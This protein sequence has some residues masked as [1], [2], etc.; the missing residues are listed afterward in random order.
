MPSF[1]N[2][3][4]ALT[5]RQKDGAPKPASPPLSPSV[6]TLAGLPTEI[7]H[8]IAHR[9]PISSAAVLPLVNKHFLHIY[10]MQAWESLK[11]DITQRRVFLYLLE[12][13]LPDYYADLQLTKKIPASSPSNYVKDSRQHY[14]STGR[15]FFL[16]YDRFGYAVVW[17]HVVLALKRNA[18]GGH[19]GIPLEA[20]TYETT[21]RYTPK[22]WYRNFEEYVQWGQL[23]SYGQP[24][25]FGTLARIVSGHLLLRCTYRVFEKRVH[26]HVQTLKGM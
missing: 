19:H 26:V 7:L 22:P 17:P 2:H 5:F 6:V 9:L 20:F 25:Q 21:R 15:G 3:L 16:N 8:S 24:V 18:Y 11:H 14:P 23:A 10:G 4:L 13:D 1:Y 12:R